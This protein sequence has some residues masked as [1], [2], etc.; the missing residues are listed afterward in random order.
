MG[1]KVSRLNLLTILKEG[2]YKVLSVYAMLTQ[3]LYTQAYEDIKVPEDSMCAYDNTPNEKVQE[4][5]GD[6]INVANF[7]GETL[8]KHPKI[9][10]LQVS[11]EKTHIA[12]NC[13]QGKGKGK[14]DDDLK[15]RYKEKYNKDTKKKRYLCKSTNHL[16]ADCD[17][18]PNDIHSNHQ[19]GN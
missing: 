1:E 3:N 15:K 14:G 2:F 17:R 18:N 13:W 6:T 19:N 4:N 11:Y 16:K 10:L 12:S 7:A 8:G 5:K 9:V